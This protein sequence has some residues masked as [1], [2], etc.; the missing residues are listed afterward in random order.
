MAVLILHGTT[1]REV[2]AFW[3][4]FAA[5]LGRALLWPVR[6]YRARREFAALAAL[7]DVELRDIGLMRSDI[8]SV[9]ALPRD[10]DPT[11]ELARRAAERRRR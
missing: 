8:I 1:R 10:I 4:R 9:T 6:F 7:N 5:M 3:P 11:Q 2:N